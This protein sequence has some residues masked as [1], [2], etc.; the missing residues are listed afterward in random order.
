MQLN[1]VLPTSQGLRCVAAVSRRGLPRPVCLASF[2]AR[3]A[4]S[5]VARSTST[6]GVGRPSFGGQRTVSSG[7]RSGV[8]CVGEVL[9]PTRCLP[10][11]VWA[12]CPSAVSARLR[13]AQAPRA[14]AWCPGSQARSARRGGGRVERVALSRAS[15]NGGCLGSVAASKLTVVNASQFIGCGSANAAPNHSVKR[16]APGV[17]VSAAYLKR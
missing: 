17:P 16:T 12:A 4:R 2:G 9:Q 8:F 11:S 6:V 5:V 15:C 3:R 1:A 7:S 14:A 10:R 13:S